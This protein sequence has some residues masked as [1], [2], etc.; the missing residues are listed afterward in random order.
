MIPLDA[1]IHF[2][3]YC[4]G[5]EALSVASAP[6][7]WRPSFLCE[8]APHP[9]Q[10]LKVRHR[11]Q[12]ARRPYQPVRGPLLW[13]DFTALRVR[14][15]VTANCVI[16]DVIGGGTPCQAF[17]RAGK[18]GSLSDAR[19]NL[20]L[21]FVRQ[22]H[23]IDNLRAA[24]GQPGLV[25]LW[26][27]VPGVLNTPDNA[28]GCFLG[29]LVGADGPVQGLPNGKPGD[30]EHFG[31]W[32][33]AGLVEGPRGRAAW[34]VLDAQ[35]FGLAQ[36]RRRVW[37]VLSLRDRIDPAAVLFERQ[38]L[39]RNPPARG[40]PGEGVAGTLA[41]GARKSG[42]YSTDDVPVVA[43]SLRAQHNASLRLDSDTYVPVLGDD[44][45]VAHTLRAEGFDASEDGTGR[46]VP[47]VPMAFGGNN[48]SGPIEVSTALN[49][50]GTA[51]GRQDFESET[52]VVDP[53]ATTLRARDGAK[54]VDS[55][56]TDTLVLC[57]A[58][59]ARPS[60]VIQCGDLSGPLDAVG[61]TIGVLAPIAFGSK[62]PGA[63]AEVD[64][65]PTLRAGNHGGSHANAG[66]PPA[67]AFAL[68]G[69]EDGA[70]P[71]VSGDVVGTLRAANGGSSRDYVAASAVRRLTPTE[72]E[73]LQ[74][75]A[76]GYTAVPWKGGTM[77][78]G[79]R[80]KMLGNSWAVNNA[81]WIV[82]RVDAQ[83]RGLPMPPP[84][85]YLAVA[86]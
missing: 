64:L 50:S 22:V 69:R 15:L 20:T 47:L 21:E 32:P 34:R 57:R 12:E 23:A 41:G 63:D 31:K 17:S 13:G 9:R 29:G 70:V 85:A 78:D 24:R 28:F 33:D 5:I 45:G 19:G 11:A 77:P 62:D 3:S 71:E 36:R 1:P 25:V 10:V 37:V 26:E 44:L 65:A 46:G 39:S 60:D 80:Y 79:P 82:G 84:G 61:Q 56:C 59:D 81:R 53:V 8:I 68:R 75:F 74:G 16:P 14:H 52:F 48:S 40:R 66:V 43:A 54:G 6:Y 4:A 73:R 76:D 58:F 42:G 18:R 27:N 86:A 55:D 72:C 35:Y 2:G 49:A 7:N 38:G 67:I 83:M 51:S 30:V